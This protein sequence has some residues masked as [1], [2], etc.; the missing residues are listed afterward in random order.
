VSEQ[1]QS[2]PNPNIRSGHSD[3]QVIFFIISLCFICGFLLAVVSFSLQKTQRDAKEFDRS[4]QMLIAAK[5]LN[6]NGHFEILEKDGSL[7]LAKFD[8]SK[9]LL[10][11]FSKDEM[12]IIATEEEI[13]KVAETRIRPLLTNKK[14]E[15]FSLPEKSVD[16][17]TYLEEHKKT[18]YGTQPLKLFYAI[19]PNDTESKNITEEQIAKEIQKASTFVF[20]VSGFG[21]WGPIYGYLAIASDGDTVIGTTWY[22]HAETPGLGANITEPWWQKQFFDKVIFQ[23]STGGKTDY[24]T[25]AMGIIVVKGKVKDV[26][27]S[28]PKAKSAVDGMSGATITGDGVTQAYR[29][30][31]EPYR[32]LLIKIHEANQ[33]KSQ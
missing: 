2:P 7:I 20:P 22:E 15:I 9:N 11:P 18:G 31:L 13:K 29:N 17:A 32:P 33:N 8:S 5:I 6:Y 24:E 14:G 30:S 28:M 10:I 12:P 19:L 3:L 4:K 27:G 25:A 23:E 21:L 26:Y 16:L 1:S